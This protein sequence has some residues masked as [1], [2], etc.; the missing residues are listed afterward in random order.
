MVAVFVHD[1]TKLSN[2]HLEKLLKKCLTPAV[3]YPFLNWFNTCVW[4][5]WSCSRTLT[6]SSRMQQ[7][8][9]LLTGT[10]DK[11]NTNI[12]RLKRPLL[13]LHV[14]SA[15]AV[16]T[17]LVPVPLGAPELRGYQHPWYVCSWA[18]TLPRRRWVWGT[19]RCDLQ[20][21]SPIHHGPSSSSSR[22]SF[23]RLVSHVGTVWIQLGKTSMKC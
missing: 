16:Q 11:V 17:G 4:N 5:L 8:G 1:I 10:L 20:W 19:A 7:V 12:R 18:M 3:N 22:G 6:T 2:F 21:R 14:Y 9:I 15:P 13:S 23:K